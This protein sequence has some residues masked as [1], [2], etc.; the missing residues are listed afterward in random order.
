MNNHSPLTKKIWRALKEAD[1]EQAQLELIASYPQAADIAAAYVARCT[2]NEKWSGQHTH[3]P[4]GRL[5]VVLVHKYALPTPKKRQYLHN[6]AIFIKTALEEHYPDRVV[7]LQRFPEH[8][9][10]AFSLGLPAFGPIGAAVIAALEKNVLSREKALE[11]L[12]QDLA[13]PIRPKDRNQWAHILQSCIHPTHE[14]ML[15]HLGIIRQLVGTG[16]SAMLELFIPPLLTH[17]SPEEAGDLALAGLYATTKKARQAVLDALADAPSVVDGAV[18]KLQERIAELTHAPTPTTATW[19]KP[20]PPWQIQGLTWEEP[21][22]DTL[23]T[24]LR[25]GEI[26][27]ARAYAVQLAYTDCETARRVLRGSGLWEKWAKNPRISWATPGKWHTISSLCDDAVEAHL[28]KIPTMLSAPSF[29]DL[30]ITID[31]LLTRLGRYEEAECDVLAPDLLLALCRLDV[32]GV[33]GAD[34]PES[35][36]MVTDRAKNRWLAIETIMAYVDDPFVEP[37]LTL[38]RERWKPESLQLPQSLAARFTLSPSVLGDS[39][40]LVTFPHFGDTCCTQLCYTGFVDPDPVPVAE[41]LARRAEPLG[42]GALMNM[43]G[44]QRAIKPALNERLMQAIS[45]AWERGLVRPERVDVAYL[46][47]KPH[48]WAQIPALVMAMRELV[49]AGML[50]L[51]W[52]IWD[53]LLE[54]M[55]KE[56]RLPAGAT[57][58]VAAMTD[59]LPAV[60]TAHP[61]AAHQSLGV[62]AMA[63]R[64]GKSQA[65]VG[66]ASLAAA[67]GIKAAPEPVKEKHVELPVQHPN[68]AE[69]NKLWPKRITTLAEYPDGAH[70]RLELVPTTTTQNR[71][72]TIITFP[73]DETG[74]RFTPDSNLIVAMCSWGYAPT[75]TETHFLF[76]EGEKA[77][78]ADTPR[79]WKQWKA[80]GREGPLHLPLTNSMVALLFVCATGDFARSYA[81]DQLIHVAS[82]WRLSPKAVATV[83]AEVVALPEFNPGKL[84][85]A[86]TDTTVA[87]LW[88]ILTESLTHAAAL[89]KPPRWLGR[90][91][92]A[93]A[94]HLGLLVAATRTGRIPAAAWAGLHALAAQTKKTTAVKKA[95]H[96]A[97]YLRVDQ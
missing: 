35:P 90:I 27:Q 76:V 94:E 33:S 42:V 58:V 1:S 85:P 3:T 15:A 57:H 67:L 69:L 25:D 2:S 39:L 18:D 28:G 4:G 82:Q 10:H 29:P 83:M 55:A 87:C 40:T 20:P 63:A 54:S 43:V 11:Y 72:D 75:A 37:E 96:I 8:L 30:R 48:G 92:G 12:W 38:G 89:E 41:Q 49:D 45:Q 16:E 81:Q 23:L 68:E 44:I 77:C 95:Q 26:E 59:F 56:T 93:V 46:D 24:A 60:I 22:A 7:F 14:E 32:R 34:L 88:P 62:Q 36:V 70:Y 80:D 17:L 52:P 51:C 31:D 6:W 47:W 19:N 64:G 50:S 73:K 71:L 13:R 5:S 86:I 74:Y 65:V 66:A 91:V 61:D 97:P 78:L 9:H 53:G 84:V 21:T 79:P